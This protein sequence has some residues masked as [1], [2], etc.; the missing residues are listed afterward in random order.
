MIPGDT[1]EVKFEWA[2]AHGWDAIELR[3]AGDHAFL[4]RLPELLGAH[5]NGVVTPTVCVEMAHFIGAF[6]RD[7]RAD[8]VAN[9]RD[10]L[11]VIAE[12]GG[13][14]AVTPA[15]WGM[16]SLRL[17]PFVPPRSPA[18][19]RAVLLD[20]LYALGVHAQGAGVSICLEP[21]N[22]YEDHMIN[23]LD[24]AASLIE[25]LGLPS[26]QIAADFFHMDIEEADINESLRNAFSHLGHVQV[27]D[28]NRLEPGAGHLDWGSALRTLAQLGYDGYYALESRLSGPA[29]VAIP[30]AAR[31]LRDTYPA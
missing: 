25:E 28:S 20:S 11:S 24:Q 7:L 16:F 13:R 12:L 10:Q 30:A 8:A 9:M 17:P 3:G 14:A 31:F 5:R 23:R 19:D 26:V 18:E 27:S 4:R 29:E 2:T 22:R 1:L 21:L 15:S 6:D